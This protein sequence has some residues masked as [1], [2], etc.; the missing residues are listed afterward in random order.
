MTFH[1]YTLGGR[2]LVSETAGLPL[3]AAPECWDGQLIWHYNREGAGRTAFRP[4][5]AAQVT[6][7]ENVTYLDP[8]RLGAADLPAEL[9]QAVAE[10]RVTAVN[11]SHSRWQEAIAF[12]DKQAARRRLH[13]LA[14]GDVGGTVL[15][16]LKLMGGD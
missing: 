16:G 12:T 10:G 3:P 14:V 13:L 11:G 1:H 6:A 8:A 15:T 4:S 5:H 2:H 7:T 9:V